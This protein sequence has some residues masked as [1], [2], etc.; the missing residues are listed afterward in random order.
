MLQ[1]APSSRNPDALAPTGARQHPIGRTSLRATLPLSI[2]LLALP[3]AALQPLLTDDTGTQGQGGNQLEFSL[4][5][6]RTRTNGVT[7][8]T[9]AAPVIYTRGVTETLDLYAGIA[10]LRV[11]PGSGAD[12]AD[13]FSNPGVGAKWRFLDANDAGTSA[14]VKFEAL[15]P[16]SGGAQAKGLG[17][18]REGGM[19][20]AIVSQELPFGAIHFNAGIG[21]VRYA[22]AANNPDET[23]VRVTMAPVWR[24]S[25]QWQLVL[26]LGMESVQSGGTRVRSGFAE[27]G[28]I[29]SPSEA[30]DLAL[31]LIQWQ[32][33]LSPRTRTTLATAGLTWRFR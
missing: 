8:R 27:L 16:V 6:T 10:W 33:N 17:S 9:D 31:G 5:Q 2:A 22:D 30:V 1:I 15:I 11:R 28:A 24:V 4:N 21:R 14:A 13:G 18:G 12:D 7:D 29:W 20:T 19:L 26:D 3:A 23:P 32:D 25:E